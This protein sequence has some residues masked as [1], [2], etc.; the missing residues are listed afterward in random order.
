MEGLGLLEY[1]EIVD[2][3]YKGKGPASGKLKPPAVPPEAGR[4]F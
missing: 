3:N 2:Y 4:T 1:P